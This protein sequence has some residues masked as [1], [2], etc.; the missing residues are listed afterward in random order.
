[1]AKLESRDRAMQRRMTTG[2]EVLDYAASLKCLHRLL[3]QS[4]HPVLS[5]YSVSNEVTNSH[6]V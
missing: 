5:A 1:M 4:G 3:H 6:S 2:A